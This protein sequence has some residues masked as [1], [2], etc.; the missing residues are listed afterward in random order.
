MAMVSL[1]VVLQPCGAKHQFK[2]TFIDEGFEGGQAAA[3]ILLPSI[4]KLLAQ[5]DTAQAGSDI[6]LD[7]AAIRSGARAELSRVV[8]HVF[9]NKQG[10]GSALVKVFHNL[11]CRRPQLTHRP[12]SS[13]RGR[14]TMRSGRA[15]RRRMTSSRVR[16]LISGIRR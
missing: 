5:A 15:S 4:N 3:R 14:C 13:A 16:R 8:V 10:L 12:A 7:T 11:C 2:E 1:W 9:V 6:V